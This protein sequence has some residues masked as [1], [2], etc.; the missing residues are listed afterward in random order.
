MKEEDIRI[1][2]VI[3]LAILEKLNHSKFEKDN[4][5]TIKSNQIHLATS[6]NFF[7]ANHLYIIL[8]MND[9]EIITMEKDFIKVKKTK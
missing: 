8:K 5:I 9:Y 7:L 1:K 3:T 2:D 4:L 6:I